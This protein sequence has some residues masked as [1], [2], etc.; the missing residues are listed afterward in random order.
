MHHRL[1][2]PATLLFVIV[3]AVAFAQDANFHIY[4]AFG[5]SNMEGAGTIQAQDLGVVDPR[6]QVMGALTC[7]GTR[8]FTQG[9]WAT[10]TPPLVR[11]STGLGIS[12]YFGRKMVA[13]LPAHIKVGIVPVAVAGCDI[14]LFDKTNYTAFVSSAPSWMKNIIDQYGGNPYARLVQVAKLAQK[15]GVVK[16]IIFHQG[17]TNTNDQEWKNKVKKV[18]DNLKADLGLGDIP[19]LA[20]ELLAGTGAC[21]SSHNVEVNKLPGVMPNAYVIS[22]AGLTGSDNAH[23]TSAS[24]RT[25][26]ERYA[27]KML[28]LVQVDQTPVTALAEHQD[29]FGVVIYP[30]PILNGSFTIQNTEKIKRVELLTIV[31]K[32]LGVVENSG[33]SASMDIQL[34]GYTGILLLRLSDGKASTC[35]KV[36]VK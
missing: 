22:S 25:Y 1:K 20:G 15:D 14:G 27:T 10:A 30:N 9:Q 29:P 34:S 21:C 35:R 8:P 26:G 12:D 4:L 33:R 13:S 2:F 18:F 19:F 6:F 17:E 31:G 16:G 3:S 32:R 24:Y 36:F 7:T 5:Q 28:T 11:C 23:F